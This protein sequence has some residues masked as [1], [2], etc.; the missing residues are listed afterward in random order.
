MAGEKVKIRK[1]ILHNRRLLPQEVFELRN[2]LVLEQTLSFIEK[3]PA[4]C[5][6]TFLP[7][8]RNK[9]IDTWPLLKL[10]SEQ[11]AKVVVSATD[12]DNHS[13]SHF[14]YSDD[15]IFENDRFG[16]PTPVNGKEA[17][18]GDIDL[19]LIPML[20]GDKH[21]N[22]IG[23]GKGYYD[24]LLGAMNSNILKIGVLPGPLFDGFDFAEAHDIQIDYCITP[25]EVYCCKNS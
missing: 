9:E 7:I 12:F 11:G 18:L 22:R 25:F 14:I 13:M 8:T 4:H 2:K 15:L 24:Q 1:S 3:Q 5:V 17:N 16:I 23:Y 10:L 6:H 21:G 19:V 20:A